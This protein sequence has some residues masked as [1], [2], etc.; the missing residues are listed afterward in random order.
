MLY[1]AVN[2]EST[3]LPA[4]ELCQR[5]EPTDS[6]ALSNAGPDRTTRVSTGCG[7]FVRGRMCDF[8][9]KSCPGPLR[10]DR[11]I[12]AAPNRGLGRCSDAALNPTRRQ[13]SRDSGFWS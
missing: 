3:R 7:I 11:Q 5:D 12:A 9:L 4:A 10:S 13:I 8:C 2:C 1:T 6:A